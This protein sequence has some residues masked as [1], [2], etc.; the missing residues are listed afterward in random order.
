MR[1]RNT[2]VAWFVAALAI[3][4]VVVVTILRNPTVILDAPEPNLET[5]VLPPLLHR[6]S[7]FAIPVSIPLGF[8][9]RRIR[10]EAPERIRGSEGV[11]FGYT[12]RWNLRFG[13]QPT[14]TERNGRVVMRTS[15]VGDVT[16]VGRWPLPDFDFDADVE[17]SV[18]SRVRLGSDARL[19]LNPSTNVDLD[20]EW[21]LYVTT[22]D[23]GEFFEDEIAPPVEALVAGAASEVSSAFREEVRE[24]WGDMC[25]NVLV[26]PESG[27][28][29]QF[30]PTHA[31]ATQPR[32][33][34]E[35]IE[36]GIGVDAEIRLG[37]DMAQPDCVALTEL[38]IAN[39]LATAIEF[40]VPIEV[41]YEQL[42]SALEER[43]ADR[44]LGGN[45]VA[46][47]DSINVRSQERS[48]LLDT[49]VTISERKW[50]GASA[51]GRVLIVGEPRLAVAQ[52]SIRFARVE[53][54]TYSRN[55]L[56]DV[57]GELGEGWLQAFIEGSVI[58]IGP[59]ID[60]S[61]Q[62][63]NSA[64]A[65][66]ALGVVTLEGRV[67][68]LEMVRLDIGPQGIRIVSTGLGTATA[69]VGAPG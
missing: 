8:L 11:G 1:N 65:S 3:A 58:D 35:S 2:V 67:D 56:A 43:Y 46:R 22:V 25:R 17:V 18:T 68:G 45:I 64:L 4:A 66:V 30:V 49:K 31:R 41:S 59:I 27:A 6:T 7:Q 19:V 40:V 33:G 10:S 57:F 61:Q 9:Q 47:I 48:L 5:V 62:E 36:V 38:S 54:D 42:G 21:D 52:R 69:Q 12:I 51:A 34:A 28:E 26:D 23:L 29:L 32:V 37:S 15:L 39:S 50:F 63:L 14:V 16:A 53:V 60:T 55:V 13:R 20:L 44:D 24:V